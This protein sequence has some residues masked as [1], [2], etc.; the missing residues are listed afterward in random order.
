MSQPTERRATIPPV[1]V[2]KIE[3][4]SVLS[5]SVSSHNLPNSRPGCTPMNKE[6]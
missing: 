2:Y 5:G 4:H 3:L 6:K 1:D